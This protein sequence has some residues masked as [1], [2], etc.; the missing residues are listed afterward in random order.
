MIISV[1]A[2]LMLGAPAADDFATFRDNFR[3]DAIAAGI[4]GTV[5]D[6]EMETATPLAIVLE[7]NESQPEFAQPV[8]VYLNSA[9]SERR[10]SDGITGMLNTQKALDQAAS[11]YGVDAHIIAAI[12]GL[13][14]SY[15]QI[16][17]KNDIV[18]ALATLAYTGR[19]QSFGR[20]QLI[21]ALKIIQ[22]GYASREDLIG[23]W[24]GAMG[25]TQFIPTTY[26]QYAVDSNDDGRRDLWRDS[27]DVFA[28]TANYLSRSGYRA[29]TPWGFEVVLPQNFAYET[30]SLRTRKTAA[31][32]S[33]AGVKTPSGELGDKVDL[34]ESASIILPAGA[35][36]P[37]FMILGNFRAIMRYN[38]ST[39]Y[40]LGIGMLSDALAGNPVTLSKDWPRD[41][42]PLGRTERKELQQALK[43]AGFDPGPV[44]GIIGAGTKSALRAWQKENGMTPDGYA[45]AKALARLKAE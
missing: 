19:R 38:N 45:S 32:W 7:R 28:S 14:S 16:M 21:A 5:Y 10:V 18:S 30:A 31:Q 43:D 27:E 40:A 24:A 35:D 26:L 2:S 6:R 1:L 13:E 42:R 3:S 39:S 20:S 23:S 15:G 34:N 41:D 17:G 12:W 11:E 44:D 8:W 25:Q 22:N 29:G 36:G 37:A 33:L 4:D 9:V